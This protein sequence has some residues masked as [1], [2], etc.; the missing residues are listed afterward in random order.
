MA[1]ISDIIAGSL[2]QGQQMFVQLQR[3][4]AQ[5]EERRLR[6]KKA[7]VQGLKDAL[8]L[9]RTDP[10]A[11]ALM[12]DELGNLSGLNPTSSGFK[13]AKRLLTTR[14]EVLQGPLKTL[15]KDFP[16]VF[17]KE[18]TIG[19][20]ARILEKDPDFIITFRQEQ[21]QKERTQRLEERLLG[22]APG[23]APATGQARDSMKPA[24]SGL[25]ARALAIPACADSRFKNGLRA[26][27]NNEVA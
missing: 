14:S 12:V 18:M 10:A 24:S 25:P 7:E 11:A 5:E 23:R 19:Q 26:L 6:I 20:L 27:S 15:Q 8:D 16:D 13:R 1:S 2:V 17:G 9:G 3:L 4:K 21:K 22:V